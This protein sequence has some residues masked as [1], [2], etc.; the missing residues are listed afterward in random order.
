[1][2]EMSN[3]SDARQVVTHDYDQVAR[4]YAE[5]ES[6]APWPRMRWVEKLMLKLPSGSAVLD[7][8]C[9]SGNPADV[10]IAKTHAVT[11]VDISQAQTGFEIL[12]TAV[13]TQ[14]EGDDEIP[15]LWLLAQK[16]AD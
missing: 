8:G 1:M 13:E 11:G 9:G 12:K 2:N 6:E 10:E 14:T 7:L 5:L 15:Y 3:K 16:P 4:A